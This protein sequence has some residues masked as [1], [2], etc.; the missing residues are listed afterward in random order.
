MFT[1]NR[2]V[3]V[4]DNFDSF[5]PYAHACATYIPIENA[6]MHKAQVRFEAG[7]SSIEIEIGIEI[8]SVQFCASVRL[9]TDTDFDCDCDCDCE[10]G[11][12]RS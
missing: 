8:D 2:S 11:H 7:E 9:D 3:S 1:T 12:D 5:I 6:V 4:Y 10:P